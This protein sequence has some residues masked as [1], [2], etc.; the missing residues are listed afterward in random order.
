MTGV[1][2]QTVLAFEAIP[3]ATL[4]SRVAETVRERIERGEIAPMTRLPSERELSTAFGV[5]RVAIREAIQM[6]QAQGYVEILPGKGTFVVAPEARGASSL[7]SWVGGRDE[8][9]QLMVELRMVVEPGIAAAAAEKI[10]PDSAEEL[11]RLARLLDEVPPDEVSEADAA[12]HRL[13]ASITEN[14][15]IGELVA[16][17]LNRTEPLR[18]RTLQDAPRRALAVRG[19][20]A[21]AKAIAGGNADA[22]RD[23]M[24]AHLE[25]ARQSL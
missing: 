4:S 13:I 2:S 1:G 10:R 8:S 20:L 15:L 22:A 24:I 23:A 14:A 9:L 17:C 25:D 18:E 19:H 6:L 21:I 16:A 5:S 7:R 11:L 12:F 3:R